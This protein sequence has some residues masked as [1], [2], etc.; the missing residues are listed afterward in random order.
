MIW[1]DLSEALCKMTYP[2]AIPA[3]SAFALREYRR[4]VSTSAAEACHA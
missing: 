3:L 1:Q 2:Y 4:I